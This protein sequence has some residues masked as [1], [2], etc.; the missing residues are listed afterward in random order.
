MWDSL[1]EKLAMDAHLKKLENDSIYIFGKH[2]SIQNIAMLW[3][4][5]RFKCNGLV[6]FKAF[7]G[8]NTISSSTCRYKKKFKEMYN[9]RDKYVSQWETKFN[10]GDCPPFEKIDPSLPPAARSAARKTEGLKK[11]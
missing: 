9:F 5:E 1:Q 11:F 3:S 8:E 4:L 2:R 6:S 7:F 10:Q